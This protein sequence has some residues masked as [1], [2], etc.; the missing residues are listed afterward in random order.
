MR[1]FFKTA[2]TASAAAMTVLLIGCE[3]TGPASSKI[4]RLFVE[5]HFNEDG[6]YA[7]LPASSA[8]RPFDEDRLES[9]IDLVSFLR[10]NSVHSLIVSEGDDVVL[11]TYLHGHDPE[12]L[13]NAHGISTTMV[14]AAVGVAL[15]E[16]R[17]KSVDQY[18]SLDL[19]QFGGSGITWRH[20]LTMTA[21]LDY[22]EAPHL[23]KSK[24]VQLFAAD[25]FSA[26]IDEPSLDESFEPGTRFHYSSLVAQIMAEGLETVYE[27]PLQ[28]IITDKIWH[29]MGAGEAAQWDIADATQQVRA[30]YGLHMTARDLWRFGRFMTIEIEDHVGP[31]FVAEMRGPVAGRGRFFRRAESRL[32]S[33]DWGYG[34]GSWFV[35]FPLN[36]EMVAGYG[37]IGFGGQTLLH[38][39]RYDMT[40]AV[41]ARVL[42]RDGRVNFIK[43]VLEHVLN[44]EG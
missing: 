40:I 21:N 37:S 27:Q 16:G 33:P 26:L 15:E 24:T 9:D 8:P 44:L 7:A 19:P 28:D 41:Q 11:E 39:P 31:D 29:P 35:R 1:H 25:D 20:L 5:S 6:T 10:R 4:G 23:L 42:P 2:L 36:G 12:T 17:I 22:T 30:G 32:V 13:W 14:S 18:I 34:F 38:I 43:S 3:A